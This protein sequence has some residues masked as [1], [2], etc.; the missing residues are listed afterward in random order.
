M[1]THRKTIFCVDDAVTNLAI[2]KNT[3][4]EYYNVF[5]MNSGERLLKILEKHIPDLILLD[6]EMPEMSGY[7]IIKI[8]KNDNKTEHVPVIFLT[9]INDSASELEGL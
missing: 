7:D 1:D 8:I 4:A 3:L 9:A 6:V 2:A 5:T